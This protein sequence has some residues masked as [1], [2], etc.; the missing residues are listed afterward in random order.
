V[1]VEVCSREGAAHGADAALVQGLQVSAVFSETAE[2]R[3]ALAI[4][5]HHLM[6]CKYTS[7]PGMHGVVAC[8]GVNC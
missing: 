2:A 1:A 8:G 6:D 7:A 3:D 4:C 5:E